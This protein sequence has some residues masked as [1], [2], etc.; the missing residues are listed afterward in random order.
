MPADVVALGAQ[1][2]D[3]WDN[4]LLALCESIRDHQRLRA[5]L[6]RLERTAERQSVTVEDLCALMLST[7]PGARARAEA[8]DAPTPPPPATPETSRLKDA[9]DRASEA[10]EAPLRRREEKARAA[11]GPDDPRR[12][13]VDTIWGLHATALVDASDRL[14]A[15]DPFCRLGARLALWFKSGPVGPWMGVPLGEDVSGIWDLAA[16]LLPL[17]RAE[18]EA[19]QAALSLLRLALGHERLDHVEAAS[20]LN[21]LLAKAE[22]MAAKVLCLSLMAAMLSDCTDEGQLSAQEFD[23]V[24]ARTIWRWRRE[25]E[26]DQGATGSL[27][28]WFGRGR[29]PLLLPDLSDAIESLAYRLDDWPEDSPAQLPSVLAKLLV[30]VGPTAWAD[31][32]LPFVFGGEWEP[33]RAFPAQ[34][35]SS[36]PEAHDLLRLLSLRSGDWR[37][38][39]EFAAAFWGDPSYALADTMYLRTAATN[40]LSRGDPALADMLLGGWLLT[41]LAAGLAVPY[42][43]D[44]ARTIRSIPSEERVSTRAV[45]G[46]LQAECVSAPAPARHLA[47]LLSYL[48]PLPPATPPDPEAELRLHLTEPSWEA[49][50]TEE[51]RGLLESEC[52]FRDWRRLALEE[53]RARGP[54]VLLT[55]WA[56]LFESLLR[57]ALRRAHRDLWPRVHD[58]T[59][60]GHLVDLTKHAWDIAASE[61]W[62]DDDPRR[63]HLVGEPALGMLEELN[64]ANR[65]VKHPGE[66]P[67]DWP[68]V[69]AFRARL[70]YGGVLRRALEAAGPPVG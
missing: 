69:A 65:R 41:R 35:A 46:L 36:L 14:G 42:P 8:D 25:A 11:F 55:P 27:L 67:P 58:R 3:T 9:Y 17:A 7:P 24:L 52:V 6:V 16:R 43:A 10:A 4:G 32:Q 2:F 53:V 18:G 50:S 26:A 21:A 13:L 63:R 66:T 39:G 62:P 60:L 38:G 40:A 20:S 48:P 70:L 12:M 5:V 47:G 33:E 54:A 61:G 49:L 1:P 22:G 59:T 34:M 30:N 31:G 28:E 57:R 56:K 29:R 64:A 44:I 37:E 51:R 68:E 19:G 15:A 23:R 45:L